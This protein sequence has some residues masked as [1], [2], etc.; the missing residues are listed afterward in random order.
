MDF[1][2]TL[3][4]RVLTDF[5]RRFVEAHRAPILPSAVA[6]AARGISTLAVTQAAH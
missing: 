6:G 3:P 2:L 5:R 4:Q 1:C